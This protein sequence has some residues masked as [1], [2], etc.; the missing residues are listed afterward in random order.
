MSDAGQKP[1][2]RPRQVGYELHQTI[3]QDWIR[4]EGKSNIFEFLESMGAWTR[5]QPTPVE[6]LQYRRLVILYAQ[7]TPTLTLVPTEV[8]RALISLH[9]YPESDIDFGPHPQASAEQVCV[10]VYVCGCG[11]LRFGLS[12]YRDMKK[13]PFQLAKAMRDVR[14]SDRSWLIDL[15]QR[16]DNPAIAASPLPAP[17]GEALPLMDRVSSSNNLGSSPSS[18]GRDSPSESRDWDWSSP[19]VTARR[20]RTTSW[21][22]HG[23]AAQSNRWYYSTAT[24]SS[25]QHGA[26]NLKMQHAGGPLDTA[27]NHRVQLAGGPL[28]A[29]HNR[30]M[31]L[32]GGPLDGTHNRNMQLVGGPFDAAH[33]RNFLFA[34]EPLA[35]THNRKMQ[36]ALGVFAGRRKLKL[37]PAMTAVIA[38]FSVVP[39]PTAKGAQTSQFRKP[40]KEK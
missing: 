10:C 1:R 40:K 18:T 26:D 20:K 11:G 2:T 38:D 30:R 19:E 17:C 9:E 16:I 34:C 12:K 8:V 25:I 27:H 24:S 23:E 35:G 3:I 7:K 14:A 5:A 28:D 21:T 22:S 6:L 15:F 29:A 13:H 37:Q 36:P 33:N 32:A 4:L 31:E 39:L